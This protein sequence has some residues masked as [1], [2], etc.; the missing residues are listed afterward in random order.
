MG[1]INRNKS[2][3]VIGRVVDDVMKTSKRVID[4]DETFATTICNFEESPDN[5]INLAPSSPESNQGEGAFCTVEDDPYASQSESVKHDDDIHSQDLCRLSL[6]EV[7]LI[8]SQITMADMER[9]DMSKQTRKD[10]VKG[11]ICFQCAKTRFNMFHW[12]YP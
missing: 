11:R 7:G 2:N 3:E 4:L 6:E 10:Y 9:Q 8:R 12:A 5:S 1:V